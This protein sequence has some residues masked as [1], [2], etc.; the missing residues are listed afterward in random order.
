[1]STRMPL[2]DA[3]VWFPPPL[4][5]VAGIG[6]GWLLDR[7]VVALR[8]PV[9]ISGFTAVLGVGALA[10]GVALAGWGMATFRRA[11]TAINPHHSASRLVVTGPYRFTRNPM[12]VGLTIAYLGVSALLATAWPL[13]L[14][15][16]VLF[17]VFHFVIQREERYLSDAFGA[18]YADWRG[19]VRRWL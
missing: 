10:I 16:V 5:F 2:A 19:R 6:V 15:P 14:L 7:Y 1:M 17:I 18:E 12:Y 11:G 9:T 8:V 13:L 3:G 4:I